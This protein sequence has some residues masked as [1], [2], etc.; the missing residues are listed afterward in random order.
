MPNPDPK[1]YWN[2]W[3]NDMSLFFANYRRDLTSSSYTTAFCCM[4]V[5]TAREPLGDRTLLLEAAIFVVFSAV[6][7]PSLTPIPRLI[8]F[9]IS[10]SPAKTP[11]KSKAY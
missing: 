9:K 6:V 11:W 3:K 4:C 8:A 10:F 1:Q 2:N 7:E 5:V